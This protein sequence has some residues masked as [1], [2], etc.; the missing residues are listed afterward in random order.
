MRFNA[1]ELCAMAN[2]R[3]MVG[4]ILT[5]QLVKQLWSPS[6]QRI[7]STNMDKFARF[8][9]KRTGSELVDYPVLHNFS[10]TQIGEFWDGLWDYCNVVADKSQPPVENQDQKKAKRQDWVHSEIVVRE[11]SSPP[12]TRLSVG[13]A[14]QNRVVQL[15]TNSI[16]ASVALQPD[17]FEGIMPAAQVTLDYHAQLLAALSARDAEAAGALTETYLGEMARRLR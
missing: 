2:K 10:V 16:R 6:A 13:K 12:A 11:I 5:Q 8:I 4:G 15:L 17:I 9:E 14:T 7:S 1:G 3:R